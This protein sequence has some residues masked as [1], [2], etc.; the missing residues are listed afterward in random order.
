MH[1]VFVFVATSMHVVCVCVLYGTV[2]LKCIFT[3]AQLVHT[4]LDSTRAWNQEIYLRSLDLNTTK[5]FVI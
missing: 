3:L 1:V 2:P 4:L 5:S